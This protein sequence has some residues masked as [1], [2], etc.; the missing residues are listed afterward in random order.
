MATVLASTRWARIRRSPMS[1]PEPADAAVLIRNVESRSAGAGRVKVSEPI[2][3][4]RVPE[5]VCTVASPGSA[6]D[7]TCQTNDRWAS[8]PAPTL[9]IVSVVGELSSEMNRSSGPKSPSVGAAAELTSTKLAA[10]STAPIGTSSCVVPSPLTVPRW[11]LTPQP[12]STIDQATVTGPGPAGVGGSD[13]LQRRPTTGQGGSNGAVGRLVRRAAN[14]SEDE[15]PGR[16]DGGDRHRHRAVD[17]VD[18]LAGLDRGQLGVEALRGGEVVG[19]HR[20]GG[21]E[22]GRGNTGGQNAGQGCGDE[23]P[24]PDAARPWPSPVAQPRSARRRRAPPRRPR[25]IAGS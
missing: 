3:E 20:L 6:N 25:S 15:G 16:V 7:T 1:G 9:R 22:Q 14:R 11:T 4:P 12:Y 23:Y 18:G 10:G 8:K 5:T 24:P 19:R 2:P 13:Q 21:A 17:G